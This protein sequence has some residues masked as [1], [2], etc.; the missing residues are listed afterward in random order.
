MRCPI[1]IIPF[2]VCCLY[3][4][5]ALVIPAS[6]CV[7]VSYSE[8]DRIFWSCSCQKLN[9][10][11]RNEW[12]EIIITDGFFISSLILEL[13]LCECN[14]WTVYAVVEWMS[15]NQILIRLCNF[16]LDPHSYS[17]SFTSCYRNSNLPPPLAVCCY[18]ATVNLQSS[19]VSDPAQVRTSGCVW[20]VSRCQFKLC[21]LINVRTVRA[22]WQYLSSCIYFINSIHYVVVLDSNWHLNANMSLNILS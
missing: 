10:R 7:L 12:S 15:S 4:W 6:S 3:A 14:F 21:R 2:H 18:R 19:V 1:K 20:T 8:S 9:C 11:S 17:E 22:C 5:C 16:P 13:C